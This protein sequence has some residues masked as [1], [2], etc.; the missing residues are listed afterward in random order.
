[1]SIVSIVVVVVIGVALW[2]L[3]GFGI[4]GGGPGVRIGQSVATVFLG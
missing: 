2:L 4:L 1:M 3:Q